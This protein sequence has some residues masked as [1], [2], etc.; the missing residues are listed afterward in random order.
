MRKLIFAF[1]ILT[2]CTGGNNGNPSPTP[3]PTPTATPSPTATPTPTPTP[4]PTPRPTPTP[5]PTGTPLSTPT[6]SP[7]PTATPITKWWQKYNRSGRAWPG[8][9]SYWSNDSYADYEKQVAYV[10]GCSGSSAGKMADWAAVSGQQMDWT[11]ATNFQ[12]CWIHYKG[13]DKVMIVHVT[14][15]I[16]D[17]EAVNTRSGKVWQDIIDG[18]HDADYVKM[19]QRFAENFKAAGADLD[20]LVLRPNH[21]MNQSNTYQVWADTRM[22]YKAA[23]ERTIDKIREGAKFHIKVFH[24]PAK[25]DR[26]SADYGDWVPNNVDGVSISFHP[27][28]TVKDRKTFDVLINGN[29]KNYGANEM[30][31]YAR[32]HGLPIAFLEWSPRYDIP[33]NTTIADQA[34][35]WSHE[36]FATVKD[37]LAMDLVFNHR[38]LMPT[39]YEGADQAGKDAWARSVTI[40]K[41]L[42]AGKKP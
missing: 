20:R 2:G 11:R 16:P 14:V 7:T 3:I 9:G 42:W 36:Y 23:M 8:G 25:T 38:T 33:N 32:A 5:S 34:M 17:S 40:F 19:G 35:T 39:A 41:T 12:P 31:A 22:K 27:G 18:K 15:T 13:I 37:I 30:V 26:L 6:P 4:S 1:L 24:A 10:D 21:E 29:D 28:A